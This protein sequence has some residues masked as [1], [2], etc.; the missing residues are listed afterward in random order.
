VM[1]DDRI[2]S[3]W[4]TAVNGNVGQNRRWE[5]IGSLMDAQERASEITRLVN[6]SCV[7]SYDVACAEPEC[8][9]GCNG[10]IGTVP[11]LVIAPHLLDV[12]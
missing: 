6:S 3:W 5:C 10:Q 4:I 12:E 1:R 9:V 11:S 8:I 7:I 2:Y